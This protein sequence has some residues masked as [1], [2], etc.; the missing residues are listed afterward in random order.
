[1]DNFWRRF[2]LS[3]EMVLKN[4]DDRTMVRSQE[5]SR[6]INFFLRNK[7]HF[8]IRII[9]SYSSRFAGHED[10]W[11]QVIKNAPTIIVKQLAIAMQAEAEVSK[12]FAHILW[13]IAPL[14]IGVGNGNLQLCQYIIEKTS[15]YNPKCREGLTPLHFAVEMGDF[16]V[17]RLIIEK[18]EGKKVYRCLFF[19]IK[20]CL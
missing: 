9:K 11:K 19:E 13:E 16:E 8:W 10:S 1:M 5:A 6:K 12:L 15:D 17:C 4:L 2:P 18:L 3:N 7:K 14:H 20:V